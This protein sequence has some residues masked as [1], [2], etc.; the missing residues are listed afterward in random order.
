MNLKVYECGLAALVLGLFVGC[1]DDS[2]SAS[3]E[4]D[5]PEGYVCDTTYTDTTAY[6]FVYYSGKNKLD[7]VTAL[8]GEMTCDIQDNYFSCQHDE[9]YKTCYVPHSTERKTEKRYMEGDSLIIYKEINILHV[10]TTFINY[11]ERRLM[12]SIPPYIKPEKRDLKGLQDAF[13]TVELDLY[14]SSIY[15]RYKGS[16][17]FATTYVVEDKFGSLPMSADFYVLKNMFE[18]IDDGGDTISHYYS[19][20]GNYCEEINRINYP[21]TP[22]IYNARLYIY[23][24]DPLE[25]DTTVTWMAY[26]TDMYGVRDST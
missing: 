22:K 16:V 12:D 3:H 2:S 19:P 20:Y 14:D 6:S 1:G 23:S 15:D 8:T 13:D 18:T 17:N 21:L 4:N 5:C 9:A 11:G 26:Y 24:H 7:T 10:D 25:K